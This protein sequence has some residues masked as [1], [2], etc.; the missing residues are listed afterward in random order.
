MNGE[1]K[2]IY[3]TDNLTLAPY[4]D[5]EGLKYVGHVIESFEDS[6]R[7]VFKVFFCFEDPKQIGMDLALNFT[8]SRE[9][10][11]RTKYAFFRNEI[12]IAKKKISGEE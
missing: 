6:N 2:N 8:S 5:M 12:A 9:K 1:Q 10:L 4:L 3:K 11:Y 7:E